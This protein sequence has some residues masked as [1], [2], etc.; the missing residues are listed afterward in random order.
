MTLNKLK[1]RTLIGTFVLSACT[2]V[3]ACG[4]SGA[5]DNSFR[6]I[7]PLSVRSPALSKHSS[8]VPLIRGSYRCK[9]NS[10]W[11]PLEWSKI[12]TGTREVV[13]AIVFRKIIEKNHGELASALV[14][15]EIVANLPPRTR[16]LR[17]G[18]L[19][20]GAFIKHHYAGGYCPSLNEQSGV[21]FTVFAMSDGHKLRKF[22]AIG[23]STIDSLYRNAL[24]VG[25]LAVFYG[26]RP[27]IEPNN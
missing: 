1:F 21:V 22:E 8:R 19:P 24:A 15:Q 3:S 11:L 6:D 27:M 20:R 18:T 5:L 2:V 4:Q 10:I 26:S 14:T 13:V 25:S 16:Q 23:T 17:A 7:V 9:R 12:P